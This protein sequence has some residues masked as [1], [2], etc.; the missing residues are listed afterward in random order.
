MNISIVNA[1]TPK[2]KKHKLKLFELLFH[3]LFYTSFI[4]YTYTLR[5]DLNKHV[6]L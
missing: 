4:I 2:K 5:T 3:Y 1:H 6:Y